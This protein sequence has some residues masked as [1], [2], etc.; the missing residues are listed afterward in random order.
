MPAVGGNSSP[1]RR[2]PHARR[3]GRRQ[4]SDSL[5]DCLVFRLCRSFC[6]WE[7][8]D[9]EK[10]GR[11]FSTLASLLHTSFLFGIFALFLCQFPHEIVS[12][13]ERR[14]KGNT[15]NSL[16]DLFL[17]DSL[18]LAARENSRSES[19]KKCFIH[20][21]M[22]LMW[23]SLVRTMQWKHSTRHFCHFTRHQSAFGNR[24]PNN[25]FASLPESN[26]KNTRNSFYLCSV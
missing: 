23:F 3:W 24:A 18:Q 10:L 9:D 2:H 1:N 17:S 11:N 20:R 15:S 12:S 26:F 5:R 4:I 8:N 6:L 22:P 7:I 14:T 16:S 13:T 19:G 21:L 25:P